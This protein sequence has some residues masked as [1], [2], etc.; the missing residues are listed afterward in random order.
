MHGQIGDL[1][2]GS[3]HRGNLDFYYRTRA[4]LIE[5]R[6]LG[7]GTID[8]DFYRMR[9]RAERRRVR[10]R[11]FRSLWPYVRPL[12]AVALLVAAIF[13]LPKHGSDC[14]ACDAPARP[15]KSMNLNPYSNL[16]PN[17]PSE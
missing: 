8:Y 11:I 2:D 6:R 16:Y 3:Q 4:T 15:F 14:P 10:R 12:A 1:R 9:A 7:G 13:M 17:N 5:A